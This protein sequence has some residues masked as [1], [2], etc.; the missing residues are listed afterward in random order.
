MGATDPTYPLLPVMCIAASVLLLTMSLNSLVRQNWN[1]GVAFLCFWLLVDNVIYAVDT[2]AWSDNSTI[3]FYIYCDI[4]TH[5]R[6]ISSVA[7]PMATFLITRRL[8]L[9]ASLR[10]VE[11]ASKKAR[12]WNMAIEWVLGFVVPLV[13]GGP[14]YY[15][16]QG[17]R[18]QVLEVF[19]CQDAMSNDALSTAIQFL[20]RV[21]TPL[22]SITIYYP[23]IAWVFYFHGRDVDRFLRSDNSVSR[24]NYLRVLALS[25]I[26]IFF[27]LPFNATNLILQIV[28]RTRVDGRLPFYPGWGFVHMEWE[29]ESISYDVLRTTTG[30]LAQTYLSFWA[31]PVLAFVT[32]GLFGLTAEAR[33]SYHRGSCAVAR[34]LGWNPMSQHHGRRTRSTLESIQFE[35]QC[36]EI[37]LNGRVSRTNRSFV[38]CTR[39]PVAAQATDSGSES[40]DVKSK[41]DDSGHEHES[42]PRISIGHGHDDPRAREEGT[43]IAPAV[44][45]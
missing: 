23:K 27:T 8:F 14:V 26:D 38:D 21:L 12:R 41:T 3:K 28:W 9:I 5:L 42:K 7:Q 18:F 44:A 31:S 20:S 36:S 17:L 30:D 22:L 13:A 24:L 4:A 33:A 11:P 40:A 45:M 29:P 37:S 16:V 25:S 2:I 32:F 34:R 10:S 6:F 39:N 19:G 43:T 15:V 35:A 1:T